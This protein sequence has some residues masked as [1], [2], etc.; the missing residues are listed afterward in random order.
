MPW[1]TKPP[2]TVKTEKNNKCVKSKAIYYTNTH[3]DPAFSFHFD[4]HAKTWQPQT[5]VHSLAQNQIISHNNTIPIPTIL[6]TPRRVPP[7]YRS[8]PRNLIDQSLPSS[9]RNSANWILIRV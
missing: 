3:N 6:R 5:P 4:F 8:G 2:S 1:Q 9:R 7:A